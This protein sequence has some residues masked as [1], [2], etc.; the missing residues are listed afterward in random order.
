MKR[1]EDSLRYLWDNMKHTNIY[2]MWV[3]EGDKREKGPEKISE[4]TIAETSLTWER[5]QS[6]KSKK[7][8]VPYR[9]NPRR[10]TLRHILI[11]LTKIKDKEKIC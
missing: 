3:P 8:R 11:R 7:C 10:N 9:I 2:I 6:P 4:E 5:E 1:N